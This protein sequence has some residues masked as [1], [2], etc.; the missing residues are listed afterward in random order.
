MKVLAVNSSARAGSESKTEIMLN[1]LVDGMREA[2][3]EVEIVNLKDKKVRVCVGCYTC[4]TKTPGKCIHQDDM[5][6]ELFPKW[7]GSD[8]CIYATPLFHHTV[9]ATMK[10]FIERTLPMV[11]PY[12]IKEDDRWSHPLRYE[13]L[14]GVV[15]LSVAGFPEM[16]AFDGLQHYTNYLFGHFKGWL[17]GEIYRPGAEV[18]PFAGQKRDDILEATRQGGRELVERK[19]ILPE[20]KDLIEQP[21]SDDMDDFAEMAN[22]FWD[23]C[24]AEGVTPRE[25]NKKG[26]LP[27]PNSISSFM[28]IFSM[29]FNPKGAGDTRAVI[30]FDFSGSVEDQCHFTIADGTMA[31]SKGPAEK[32]DLIIKTPFDVWVDIMTGKADGAEMMMQGKYTAEGDMNLLV[33]M[34]QFFGGRN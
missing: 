3:A 2:G 19:T 13:K 32:A 33:N 16:S 14:P 23:T 12:L 17:W 28:R 8:L 5:S 22:I 7:I 15:V 27:R 29:G 6:K 10:T 20:T 24:I 18:L 4:W 31:I 26:L 11:E 30:Q 9:N 25:F 21:I 1:A 34:G